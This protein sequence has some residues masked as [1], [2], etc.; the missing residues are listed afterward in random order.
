MKVCEESSFATSH[1]RKRNEKEIPRG[2]HPRRC[3][4]HRGLA[5]L[6]PDREL[7]PVSAYAGII[8]PHHGEVDIDYNEYIKQMSDPWARWKCPKCG[9]ASEFNE[10]RYEE[11][12][13]TEDDQ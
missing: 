8:C 5:Q 1:K 12:N 2:N 3:M 10:A 6:L 13:F 11:I 9:A 4:A 7:L